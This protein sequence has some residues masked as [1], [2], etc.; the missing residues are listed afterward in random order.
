MLLRTGKIV[1][2][3]KRMTLTGRG[4]RGKKFLVSRMEGG[5]G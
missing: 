5:R 3:H 2:L 1:P 4:G